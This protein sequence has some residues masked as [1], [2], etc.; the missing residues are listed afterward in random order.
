M[1]HVQRVLVKIPSE[2]SS[3]SGYGNRN[4]VE[5]N[6]INGSQIPVVAFGNES[7]LDEFP[8]RGV[9]T[10]ERV[11]GSGYRTDDVSSASGDYE[12]H[13]SGERLRVSVNRDG[14]V[15]RNESAQVLVS[16]VRSGGSSA[17]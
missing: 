16:G 12:T 13:V 8:S 1:V 6:R 15:V 17:S 11:V 5:G 3:R 10:D 7:V 14:P 2:R 9:E 4:R